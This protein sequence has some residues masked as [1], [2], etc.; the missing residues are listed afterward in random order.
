VKKLVI[1]LL[2]V[3]MALGTMGAAFA[4]NLNFPGEPDAIMA[5]GFHPIEDVNC[6]GIVFGGGAKATGS[7]CERWH[8]DGRRIYADSVWVKFDEDLRAC[9]W[10]EVAVTK[11]DNPWVQGFDVIEEGHLHLTADLPEDT[12]VQVMLGSNVYLNMDLNAADYV[13]VRV[14]GGTYD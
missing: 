13:N 2:V 11:N 9:T 14:I 4:T 1:S 7:F 3:V 10:I 5:Q 12:W 6:T 8:F